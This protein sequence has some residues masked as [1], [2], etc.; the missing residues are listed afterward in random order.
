MKKYIAAIVN[1]VALLLILTSIGILVFG[2][3]G[4]NAL[5]YV[6]QPDYMESS[7]FEN[8]ASQVMT[9]IFDYIQLTDIF[10]QDGKLNLNQVIAQADVNGQN[11]SYSLD[12][13]VQYGRSMGYYFDTKNQLREDGP[14]TVT[15]EMDELKHQIIVQYRAY[16]PNY[17]QKSPTDGQM[18]LGTLTKE[19]MTYLARY[20]AVKNEFDASHTNFFFNVSYQKGSDSRVYTNAPTRTEADI[21]QLPKYAYTDSSSLEVSSDFHNLPQDLVMLLQLRSPYGSNSQYRFSA[22]IDTSFPVQDAFSIENQ[23]YNERRGN[24]MLGLTFLITSCLLFLGSLMLLVLWTG[25]TKALGREKVHLYSLDRLPVELRMLMGALWGFLMYVLTPAF[26][27]PLEGI[28]GVIDYWEFWESCI[29]FFMDYCVALPLALSI[30]RSCKAGRLW[31]DSVL[32]SIGGLFGHYIHA[33]EKTSPKIFTYV[34][35]VL[36]NLLAV[37][38]VVV[39][40][41]HFFEAQSLR[42]FLTALG[43]LLILLAI[44]FYAWR[45][46]T[47]LSQAVDEQV[48]AERLKADLITNVSH[49]LKT[50]LTSIISYVDL[51]KRENIDNPNV[52][53]YLKVLDQKSTRLKT[54]TEDLVEASK[55]SSGNVKIEFATIN[56]T[57]IVEQALGEFENKTQAAKLEMVLHYPEQPVMIRADGRHLWRVIENLLNNC[58]KYALRGSRV[59]VDVTEDAEHGTAACTIKNISSRPLNISPEELT[60]RFVRGDV[61]RTTEGSGLG[62]SIAKSLTKLMDGELVISIDGDLYKAAVVLKTA[63]RETNEV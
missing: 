46:S 13:L 28:L 38:M 54:L 14:A 49:D 7:T 25:R 63:I 20:Y 31:T 39:L 5:E 22:G 2:A 26:L 40:F 52:Q 41:V 61:S 30:V 59:Y 27:G 56:Y 18:S 6:S 12:Y 51:L 48:K 29:R 21:R 43:I 42:A 1:A 3:A 62:L 37:G 32:R 53:E 19:A 57:E 55:A 60:E 10:E 9:D 47:G 35:F 45:I 15:Q 50:P 24:S 23:E 58:C 34:L 8:Q 17:K 44:D 36:P 16:M 33:A 11:I 4:G